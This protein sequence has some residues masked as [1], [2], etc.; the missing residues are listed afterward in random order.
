MA[1]LKFPDRR[2][3]VFLDYFFADEEGCRAVERIEGKSYQLFLD[4][5]R[6]G[7]GEASAREG[8][9]VV[10]IA[11]VVGVLEG[12]GEFFEQKADAVRVLAEVLFGKFFGVGSYCGADM[13]D[14]GVSE[15]RAKV[16]ATQAA[17][18]AVD[19]G[20]DFAVALMDEGVETDFVELRKMSHFF[21]YLFMLCLAALEK[22]VVRVYMFLR[23]GIWCVLFYQNDRT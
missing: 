22:C 11:G 2:R 17:R 5:L 1:H 10:D 14:V 3:S 13:F 18:G 21:E 4:V 20:E 19:F 6:F 12:A 9:H 23:S 7:V 16:A 15:K 8:A